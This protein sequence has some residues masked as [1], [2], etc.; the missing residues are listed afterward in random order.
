MML[1]KTLSK[2]YFWLYFA[3]SKTGWQIV[4]AR[5]QTPE[6]GVTEAGGE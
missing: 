2:E 1:I 6:V 3:E 4:A 5:S